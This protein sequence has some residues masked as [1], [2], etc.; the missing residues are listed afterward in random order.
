MD[1]GAIKLMNFMN[2]DELLKINED[3]NIELKKA[4]NTVPES[5]WETY[6][7]FANTDGGVV[8]FG[9]DE[10]RKQV[11]GV[12]NP[13]KIKE[14]LLNLSNNPQKVSVNMLK[15]DN[16]QIIT[17]K[18]NIQVMLIRIPEASY[19]QKPV[20][21][22]NNPILAYERLGEGDRKLSKEK[23]KELVVNS[24]EETDNELLKNYDIDDLNTEDLEIYKKTLYHQ[25]GSEKYLSMTYEDLLIEIG[26]MRKDRQ[27][28]GRYYLT[29]GGLLFF[30][31]TNAITDRF[32]GFQLDYFEKDSSLVTDWKDR[33]SSGDSAYS[34]MN[35]YSFFRLVM[36]KMQITV[37]DEFMLDENTK[38]RL[39]FKTDLL[40]SVREALVNS[41]MHAYYDSD[42]AIKITAYPDYYEFINPGKMRISVEEFIHG[43]NSNI[44]NHTMSSIMRRIGISEKAGSGGPRIF[45]IASRY[46]LKFPEIIREQHRTLV[47]IWKV[48]LE[49][50]FESYQEDQKKILYYLIENQTI[51][52]SEA[53]E[54]LNMDNHIFR[55]AV[56]ELLEKGMIE[57]MGKGRSTKYVLTLSSPEQ[58]YIVKKILRLIE[59]RIVNRD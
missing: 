42:N 35:V 36:D 40:T 48:D 30:G 25:T 56:N 49:K 13:H 12:K 44:R 33:I 43:G 1:K 38:T 15:D 10:E 20:Y 23:Y 47:R 17:L 31:K 54:K 4:Q 28:D 41:L 26:A 37:K 5:F 3:K 9:V 32:P 46:K 27:G 39:P 6:S 19:Q 51:K 22:K 58:S 53:N 14:D 29:T 2:I 45:D 11:T 52:R 18:E 21:L 59:D 50:T 24:Q 7:A 34:R 8:I 57:I 55:H 16:I